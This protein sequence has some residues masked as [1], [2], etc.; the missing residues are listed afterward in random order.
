MASADFAMFVLIASASSLSV[1]AATNTC[2]LTELS[3]T[4]PC[5]YVNVGNTAFAVNWVSSSLNKM[6]SW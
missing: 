4:G 1:F 6:D 3:C 2:P 5:V